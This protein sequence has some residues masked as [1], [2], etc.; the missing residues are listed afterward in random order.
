[1]YNGEIK[2]GIIFFMV[3]FAFLIPLFALGLQ[4]TPRGLVIILGI[5]VLYYFLVMGEATFRSLVNKSIVLKSYNKWYVYVLVIILAN[6][7]SGSFKAVCKQNLIGVK[8]F[9]V[10]TSSNEPTLFPGDYIVVDLRKKTP[11]KGIFIV[12]TSPDDPET[13]FMKRVIATSG[14]LVEIKNKKV[15]VNS[16]LL[17]EPYSVHGD[18]RIIPEK[19]SPRDNFGPIHIPGQKAF[20]M[21]DNRDNSFDSRFFGPIDETTIIGTCLYIYWARDKQR[22]GM[23]VQ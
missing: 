15:F 6:G 5:F 18:K 17:N 9:Y 1:M 22:I 12:F 16:T 13:T 14:D 8:P 20:V 3:Q 23:L 7:I 11:V 4:Y 10:P 21:G 2:K 19:I